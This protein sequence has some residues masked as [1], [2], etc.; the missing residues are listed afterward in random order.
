MKRVCVFCGS[1]KGSN[2]IYS[3]VAK[4]TGKVIVRRGIGLVYGGGHI[5]LMGVIADTVIKEG[6][7][8]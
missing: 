7:E 6:G 3:E 5:G 1:K 8:V 2:R 4:A